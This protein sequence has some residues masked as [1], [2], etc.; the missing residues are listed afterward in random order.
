M[1]CRKI[2]TFRSMYDCQYSYLNN[3]HLTLL[4]PF[5]ILDNHTGELVEILTDLLDSYLLN[6]NEAS[7]MQFTSIDFRPGKKG[8]VFLRPSGNDELFHCQEAMVEAL[9]DLGASFKIKGQIQ[10]ARKGMGPRPTFTPSFF[11]MALP[12]ARS[13][14]PLIIKKAIDRALHEFQ[15]PIHLQIKDISLFEKLPGSWPVKKKFFSFENK[16]DSEIKNYFES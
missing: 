9:L 4:P 7:F 15:L 2:E 3:T 1:E 8:I 13:S 11:E 12:M 14:D 10:A 5:A 16:S 6:I